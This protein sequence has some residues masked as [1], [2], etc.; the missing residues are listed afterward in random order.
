MRFG[1]PRLIVTF[2]RGEG[3]VIS[4]RLLSAHKPAWEFVRAH[5]GYG[6]STVQVDPTEIIALEISHET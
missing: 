4:D 6:R 1:S 2:R 5:P 3:G